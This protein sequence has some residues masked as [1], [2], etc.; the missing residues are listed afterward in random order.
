METKRLQLN[1][2]SPDDADDFKALIRDKMASP[3]AMYDH[4][5]PTDDA[6]LRDVLNYFI[7]S[8]EFLAV[9]LRTEHKVIGFIA[10]NPVDNET[11]NLGYCIRSDYQRQ[12]YAGEAVAAVKE[13]ARNELRVQR[14][15]SGTA[16]ANTPSVRLLLSAGFRVTGRG[17]ESLGTSAQGEPVSFVG[18]TLEC[19]L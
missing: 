3:Y 11:R 16:E 14:L 12:G 6:G 5:F 13:Y 9:R 7:G 4:A 10:L 1:R 2:F 15:V 17:M 8:E 18:L 19:L